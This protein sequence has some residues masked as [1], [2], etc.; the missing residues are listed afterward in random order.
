MFEVLH[1][2]RPRFVW[3][4]TDCG[5]FSPMQNLNQRTEHQ[6]LELLEKQ[7]DAR[8]QHV[9]GLLV[10]YEALR[11]GSVVCWEWSRRCRA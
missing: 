9:G 8:K 11:L 7:R 4:A 6:K 1:T 10:A 5:A 3:I 2:R